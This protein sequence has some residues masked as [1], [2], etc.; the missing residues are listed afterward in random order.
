MLYAASA[1][2]GP[3]L[4]TDPATH[5]DQ[6]TGNIHI[7]AWNIAAASLDKLVPGFREVYPNCDVVVSMSG[8]NLQS[9]FL[10]SLS[11]GVGA[12]DI[13]Q[14]QVREAPRYAV[15][16]RLT[17][18]T[19]VA[20]KYEK[21]FAASFWANCVYE[22]RI[23]AIP[24]DM[25]PCGVFYKR[26]VFARYGIDPD[27]IETWD[28]FTAAGK[29]LLERSNGKTKML[30]LPTGAMSDF[31]EILLQQ[32]SGQVF[33]DQGRI[34]INS[35]ETLEVLEVLK[36]LLEAGIGANLEPSAYTFLA[37]F[38]SD[39]IATYPSA[40]WFGG[41]IRDYAPDSSG[42][43]GVFRLP[44]IHPGGLRTSNLGGSV[45]VIPDQCAQKEAAWTYIEYVLCTPGPQ[46]EQ[47]RNFDLFPA[48]TT[49]HSDPFFQEPVPFFGGQQ[50]RR[51]FS[52]DIDKIPT[53]NRTTDWMEALRYINQALSK[54]A[55]GDRGSTQELLDR[56]E[57][58]LSRRLGREVAPASRTCKKGM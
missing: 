22:G 9:R 49:T 43:W 36:R 53:I 42:D 1:W 8:A 34:A 15:T 24:W 25:G 58:K 44:A 17:D 47:Y 12:P 51:L 50:V 2:A 31:F 57:E 45:L 33:D 38:K 4:D 14:L 18:L 16:G 20:K 19:P 28:D 55:N 30:S 29:Q 48:L 39:T 41:I 27:A 26:S 46:I 11:A 37:S 32:N 56:L 10:L 21:A 13:S 35:P 54:W 40:A 6:V 52:L 5:S 23:Y 7:W 3:P